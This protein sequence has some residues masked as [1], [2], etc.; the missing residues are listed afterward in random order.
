MLSSPAVR[1]SCRCLDRSRVMGAAVMNLLVWSSSSAVIENHGYCRP[2][3]PANSDS[4]V[5][6]IPS[7]TKGFFI[8]H[9]F[10]TYFTIGQTNQEIVNVCSNDPFQL[11][12]IRATNTTSID[13]STW[14]SVQAEKFAV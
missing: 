7:D 14:V 5:S 2:R 9:P 4:E 1:D 8:R 11:T 12:V 10:L 3:I 6:K 13:Q